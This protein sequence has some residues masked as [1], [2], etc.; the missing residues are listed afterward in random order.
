MAN[1]VAKGK[2]LDLLDAIGASHE[3]DELEQLLQR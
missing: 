2:Q 3:D 1:F